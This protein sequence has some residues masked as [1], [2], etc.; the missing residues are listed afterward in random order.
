MKKILL[1]A[2]LFVATI[3]AVAQTEATTKDGKKV[4]LNSNGTWAY[5]DGDCNLL[6]ETKTYTGGKTMTSAKEPIK[7][8]DDASAKT[9]V[10]LDAIKG[11]SSLILNFGRIERIA[12]CINKNA[13]LNLEFTDGTKLVLKHMGELD[14]KGNFSCFLGEQ[15]NTG[16]ELGVLKS[17]KI[18]K[19]SIEYTDTENGAIKKFTKDYTLT[20]D[21]GEKLSKI[22]NCLSN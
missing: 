17:K 16:K 20:A 13:P 7:L 11:S 12:I 14:C 2:A 21:Q 9:G 4:V 8:F 18:K 1:C 10:S 22:I 15:M 6:T 3:S 5:A 19:V